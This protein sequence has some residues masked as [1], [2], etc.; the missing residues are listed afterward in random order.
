MKSMTKITTEEARKMQ[1][2]SQKFKMEEIK[3]GK[4]VTLFNGIFVGIITWG[5]LLMPNA[6]AYAKGSDQGALDLMT[7]GY[8]IK[9]K[10]QNSKPLQ[11]FPKDV[12]NLAT[13][14][15]EIPKTTYYVGLEDGAMMGIVVGPIKGTTSMA[16][17]ISK[18]VWQAL[19]SDKNQNESK[20]L[21]FNY[22]F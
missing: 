14:W 18:G 15:R 10:V 2:E 3:K 1:Y 7:K 4:R 6:T 9:S 21:K 19:N 11:Q 5:M 16:R 20:G 12:I 22:K 8:S 13:A 17:K